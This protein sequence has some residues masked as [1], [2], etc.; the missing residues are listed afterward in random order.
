ML[1]III[2]NVGFYAK[3]SLPMYSEAIALRSLVESFGSIPIEEFE[4][5]QT[6]IANKRINR[7]K[8]RVSKL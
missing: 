5:E 3:S 7:Q 2:N 8:E 4:K 6:A 1:T